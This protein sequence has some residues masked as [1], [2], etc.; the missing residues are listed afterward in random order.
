L[1]NKEIQL[2][3]R[4]RERGTKKPLSQANVFL[5][6]QGL[7]ATTDNWGHFVFSGIQSGEYEIVVN[8]TGYKKFS[9]RMDVVDEMSPVDLY[10]ER[11]SYQVFETTISDLRS[12]K[13]VSSKT[14]KQK[15][16]LQVPGS[17][18]DP[19]RAVQNLPGVNRSRGGDSRIVIQGSDPDDTR[20]HINGHEVPI[21]FHFGGLSSILIPEAVES[22]DYFSAGY[23]PFYSEALGGHIGLNGRDPKNDRLQGMAFF[24]I[25]N[26]G[27]L[28]EGPID[29][30]SSFLVGGRYSYVGAVLRRI[31]E[32]NDSLSL[33]AAPTFAD[34]NFQYNKKINE[35]NELN[36]FSIYSKDTLELVLNRPAGNDPKIRGNFFQSTEFFRVIPRWIRKIDSE[37]KLDLSLGW[38]QNDILVDVGENFFKLRSN[39]LSHRSEYEYPIQSNW[40]SQIGADI[41]FIWFDLGVKVPDSFSAGG[42]SSP[43][44][45]GELREA[46]L[47]GQNQNLAAFW[48]NEWKPHADSKWTYLPGIRLDSFSSTREILTQPRF[49]AKYDIDPSFTYRSSLGL[50]FQEPQGQES[51]KNF[52]NPNIKSERAYHF[53]I[54]LDRDYRQGKI[55][56]SLLGT[57][58]FYKKLDR[59]IERSSE[60]VD[61]DGLLTP[62]NYNNKGEG[63]AV[64]AEVQHKW[65]KN[66]WGATTS[67]TL[68]RSR[69]R[70]PGLGEIPAAFD[71]THSLN[72]LASYE[73]GNWLYG[74]RLRYVTGNPDTPVV[75]SYFDADNDVYLPERGP[76]F[77]T[78]KRDFFQLDWRVDRKFIRDSYILS[79]YLDIQNV[80][81]QRNSESV[82]YSYDYS[83]KVDVVG[84]PLLPTFGVKGE[85]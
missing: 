55:D 76:L 57:T 60:I 35:K 12:K 39:S 30:S 61:K 8:L 18:G 62:E 83:K 5:L 11:Q 20:Y 23:G 50:Y 4:L 56:G 34:F 38:G 47:K 44:A 70:S 16:F 53:S 15:D 63:Y 17:G 72:V 59:L 26:V 13:D 14:L 64:G 49:S 80:T 74:A 41:N 24:D 21:I 10:I 73:S 48:K 65:K 9:L 43:L 25:F 32:R 29:S 6:P 52:G 66:E 58:L 22:V 85:F 81:S 79:V 33:T 36:F 54:G 31:T 67:Y 45:S 82:M 40:T 28:L 46:Q 84:L 7:R 3:G 78:R 51:N 77:S 42:V 68:S 19:I 71:Q 1:N 69:R 75:G 2:M 27:G 37:R